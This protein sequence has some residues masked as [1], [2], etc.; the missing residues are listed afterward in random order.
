MFTSYNHA[1]KYDRPFLYP[2][3]GPFGHGITR[4]Y[5]M[6]ADVPGETADHPHHCSLYTAFG[7]VNGVDN[8][9]QETGHGRI[10]HQAFSSL[11]SGPVYGR[12]VAQSDWQDDQGKKMFSETREMTFFNLPA[13]A[14]LLDYTVTFCADQAPLTLGDTKEGGL[15]SVRVA[16][17]MDVKQGQ[18]GAITN[19]YGGLN[20]AETW[21]KRS[22]WCDY[23]GPVAGRMVGIALMDHP[24][25]LRYPTQW[26]VRDYGLMAANCFAWSHYEHNPS[27]SG[28][29]T[30]PA[31][32]ALTFRYR[33]YIHVGDGASVPAR[34]I[35]F[36][37]PPQVRVDFTQP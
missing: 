25:N 36:I 23:A 24:T 34:F 6:I 10:V 5:P 31:H 30:I 7:D 27:V 8:W 16:S 28:S 32:S 9:S 2:V 1:S 12:I 26:H 35:D 15:L 14:R 22:P 11:E 18:G 4:N 21:G 17:S 33:I 19:A 3:I 13:D 20:E 37:S 29:Y